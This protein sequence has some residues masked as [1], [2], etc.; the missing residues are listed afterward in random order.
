MYNFYTV[1]LLLIEKKMKPMYISIDI[2][3][4]ESKIPISL[5]IFSHISKVDL[6][7]DDRTSVCYVSLLYLN[8]EDR[9]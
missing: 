3:R 4:K 1:T 9:C 5:A 2:N 6:I 7:F 8:N